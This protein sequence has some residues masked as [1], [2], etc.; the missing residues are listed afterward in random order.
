MRLDNGSGGYRERFVRSFT[1]W[2]ILS[3]LRRKPAYGYE[4]ISVIAGE[5]RVFI[6]PGSLY[7]ILHRLEHSG[8]VKGEWDVPNRRSRKIYELTPEGV[9]AHR[10]GLD[11]IGR[12]LDS[13]QRLAG[14][15]GPPKTLSGFG[16][17]PLESR[18]AEP[19]DM[20]PL[21]RRE[22]KKFPLEERTSWDS[23]ERE[24]IIGRWRVPGYP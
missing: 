6:S 15:A 19:E 20:A 10:D 22:L 14:K 5:F 23:A 18:I 16:R 9:R 12:I 1:D 11:S 21:S 8:F 17:A 4:M 3:I 2:L 24:H 13:F 7:P